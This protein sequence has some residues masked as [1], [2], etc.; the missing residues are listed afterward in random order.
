MVVEKDFRQSIEL[1]QRADLGAKSLTFRVTQVLTGHGCFGEYLRRIGA[2]E[3]T[4]CIECG[5]EMDSA[6]HTIEE[7]PQYQEARRDL[8]NVIGADL[9]PAALVGA[10]LGSESKRKAVPSFCEEVMAHKEEKERERERTV[11]E[12][13][14]K[15]RGRAA[16]RRRKRNHIDPG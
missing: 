11:P 6:Q 15:R 5:A 7:C 13:R 12:K 2:E 8:T 1:P 14:E 4:E 16:T 10:L 3:T 9:S